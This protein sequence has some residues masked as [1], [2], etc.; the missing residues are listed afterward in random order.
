MA[1][2]ALRHSGVLLYRSDDLT[3]AEAA[4]RGAMPLAR[5]L[6]HRE[7]MKASSNV[8]GLCAWKRGRLDDA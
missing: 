6:N 1:A 5:A 8:L 4:A 3:L 7:C 2:L